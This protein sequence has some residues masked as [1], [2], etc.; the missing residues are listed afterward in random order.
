MVYT[1]G[2]YGSQ[3]YSYG[4]PEPSFDRWLQ[5]RG[6]SA[7]AA[8]Q[9]SSEHNRYPDVRYQTKPEQFGSWQGVN[10]HAW[11][12][13][14]TPSHND[15]WTQSQPDELWETQWGEARLPDGTVLV[16]QD[17]GAREGAEE[18][19]LQPIEAPPPRRD[20]SAPASGAPQQ[21]WQP[22]GSP[23]SAAWPSAEPQAAL[24]AAPH[25]EWPAHE[26]WRPAGKPAGKGKGAAAPS[27]P[28]HSPA[29]ADGASPA[30]AADGASPAN[31][32]APAVP[33]AERPKYVPPHLRAGVPAPKGSK[34]LH[35]REIKPELQRK[36]A[37]EPRRDLKRWDANGWGTT[38][39]G[40]SLEDDLSTL[41]IRKAGQGP[42][43]D[44]FKVNAEKFGYK[45]TYKADL[46]QYTTKLDI[47]SLTKKQVEKATRT[48]N[49][50]NKGATRTLDI[51]EDAEGDFIYQAD[52]ADEDDGL[53]TALKDV[54]ASAPADPGSPKHLSSLDPTG[55][56]PFSGRVCGC[57][58]A[59]ASHLAHELMEALS[60]DEA[61][62]DKP[63]A[64][65]DKP[66]PAATRLLEMMKQKSWRQVQESLNLPFD[67]N[68]IVEE[69]DVE[70]D[71]GVEAVVSKLVLAK[72][73]KSKN[74]LKHY[75]ILEAVAVYLTGEYFS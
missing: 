58:E 19:G 44:Q 35:D 14:S 11:Q 28:A 20:R 10:G 24:P 64:G 1:N 50:I 48:A 52:D 12:N 23:A 32:A 31:G 9:Q 2:W 13:G 65:E 29:A 33:L 26:R 51:E 17:G 66:S 55:I 40:E 73:W 63:E 70:E 25:A 67:V 15:G 4:R 22:S 27:A 41:P 7:P 68:A 39:M 75:R 38:E 8:S 61:G 5:Y 53:S 47:K 37:E 18:V 46:S 21:A 71:A 34:F 62:E 45:S 74:M 16:A 59:L 3:N 56:C 60:H 69:M 6:A 57:P 72:R 30:T 43:W 54:L 36:M 49:E 42:S